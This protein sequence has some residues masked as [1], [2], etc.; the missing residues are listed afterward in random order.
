MADQQNAIRERELNEKYGAGLSAKALED[1]RQAR[2]A[3]IE[4]DWKRHPDCQ[5]QKCPTRGH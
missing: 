3:A 2:L 5:K 1:E 4:N